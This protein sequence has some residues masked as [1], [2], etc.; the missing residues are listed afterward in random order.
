ML[1]ISLTRWCSSSRCEDNLECRQLAAFHRPRIWKTRN[2]ECIGC[3]WMMNAIKTLQDLLHLTGL[4]TWAHLSQSHSEPLAFFCPL[5]KSRC[6]G[7]FD[8]VV[9]GL[10][11]FLSEGH[12][13][14]YT[15]VR[16]PDIL[17]NVIVS[18]YVAFY[19]INKCF[20]NKLF[21]HSWQNVFAGL[22]KWLR[23]PSL[24]TGLLFGD[25]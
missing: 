20:V 7:G 10:Q 4:T 5:N 15:T 2:E 3:Q 8:R 24:A 25:H 16:G 18:G 13:S 12:I 1:V 9:Q 21:F 23:G 11:N 19:Q 17:R 22:R 6:T 14:Y